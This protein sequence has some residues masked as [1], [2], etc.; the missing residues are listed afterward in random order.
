MKRLRYISMAIVL[1]AMALFF[2]PNEVFADEIR[3]LAQEQ[4]LLYGLGLNVEPAH[5]TVPKNI[6]TIVS[7]YLQAPDSIPDG[8][9]PIPED[10]E[11]RATLRGPSLSQPVEL[12]TRV[13]EPFEIQPFQLAGIH[14]L[15]NIRIVHN[16]EVILYAVPESVT[17]EVIDQLL[18]TEVTARALTAAEIQEK[19]IIFDSSNFQ[20]YNFTAAFAVK[21][22]EDITIDFPV[23][24]PTLASAQDVTASEAEIP[25]LQPPQLQSIATIIPDTL[26]VAQTQIP[27]LMVKG[28]AIFV[29][30]ELAGELEA[31]PIPGVIVIPGNIGF[32]NQYFSVM[33]MVG[34]AAPEGS[35]LIVQ[36]LEAEIVLPAGNDTVVGSGDD[37]LSMAI[38]QQGESP[39]TQPVAKAGEDGI[40][41]TADDENFIAPGETGNAEF[42]VEGRREGSHVIE[43]E[44]SGTLTGLPIGPVEIRGRA[45]GAVLVR[46]PSFTL[47]FTH[48][49]IVNAG[50]AYDLDVTVTNTSGSPANFVSVNLYSR[51]ISGASLEGTDTHEVETIPPGDAAMVSFRLRSHVTGSVFATTLDSDEKVAGRFELKTA[52]GELGIPLSPDSL[53]L[54]K[55]AGSLP[56][57]LRK[58]SVALL[59]KAYAAATCPASALP[60]DV[61]RFTQNM[62]WDRAVEVAQAGLRY[63][64]H[65]PLA[66][67][68]THLLMDFAGGNYT[69]LEDEYPDPDQATDLEA[70]Q[71]DF[72]G[73]DDLRRRSF[74]GDVL[75]DEIAQ[76][77][78]DDLASLG[79]VDFH[80]QWAETVS[81]RPEHLSVLIG[82]DGAALPF[83]LVV[84]DDKGNTLGACD[85]EN[86]KIIKEIP[87]S[88]Y[89]VF[90]SAGGNATAQMALIASPGGTG[91]TIRLE[92]NADVAPGTPFSLSIVLPADTPSRLRQVVFSGV[93]GDN[94]I[95]VIEPVA[96]DPF[97]VTV[98]MVDSG[99]LISGPPLQP[100]STLPITDPPPTVF[101]TVQ[102]ADADVF[103]C[104]DT[105]AV[106]RVG[107][108]VASLFSEEVTPESVQDQYERIDI[109]N[110]TPENNAVVGVALQPG[111]RIVYLALRD[112]VGPFIQ[113]QMTI[114]N[115]RDLR[116]QEMTGPWTGPM[117]PTIEDDPYGVVSGTVLN[118]DGTPVPYADVR[119]FTAF[120]GGYRGVS[121]KTT[122]AD[123]NYTWDFVFSASKVV[124]RQPG[125]GRIP[126]HPLYRPA[127]RSAAEYRCGVSGPRHSQW[128]G[129]CR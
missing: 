94:G 63:T 12:V 75:A 82:T 116:G 118:A 46:N 33:L 42:L 112:P 123:G 11:V 41:G 30:A 96:G 2:H 81:F 58:A 18:V 59:G 72:L 57:S 105:G 125:Y 16:D 106:L 67:T 79:L 93:T 36:D 60:Q 1:V 124:A 35:G 51:N 8:T 5:Q 44:I 17:I 127:P 117:E 109:D 43:M 115:A 21:P 56:E 31:P 40:L 76:I 73:F 71:D 70:A 15:E 86:Q 25:S 92:R 53:V 122:D 20:A 22:G 98:E 129:C 9:L 34:N 120:C 32:L 74:R 65:E 84:V 121:A 103:T 6:A 19:G 54:P 24:L 62:V 7:T 90:E 68:A 111:G 107:R 61:Q 26:K 23:L 78:T 4:I 113:R 47:T 50:E 110:Y 104:E 114:V 95:P 77:L 39:R 85:E 3:W 69:R 119:L 29:D 64:L 66:H 100:V 49:E 52:V 87:F 27:N 83:R 14:T 102:M 37:P 28:F 48:P 108:V 89:L 13:N 38:T 10:A 55:E 128:P 91:Y 99:E 88:D 126:V 80:T 97:P 45:A 101:S